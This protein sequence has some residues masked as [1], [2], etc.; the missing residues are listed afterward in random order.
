MLIVPPKEQFIKECTVINAQIWSNAGIDS[1]YYYEY[2]ELVVP[3]NAIS[4]LLLDGK[5]V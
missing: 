5:S 1:T 4:S 3:T 2:L